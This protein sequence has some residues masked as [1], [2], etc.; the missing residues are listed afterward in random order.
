[1]FEVTYLNLREDPTAQFQ[2]QFGGSSGRVCF[3]NVLVEPVD[4]PAMSTYV[5]P[6][7]TGGPLKNYS[8]HV[9]MGTA[10]D[11]PIFLS[12]PEHNAIVA[13]EFSMITPA[14]AMKMNII[15]PEQV[16][17]DFTEADA[18]LSWAQENDLEFH[19]HPLLW[20]RDP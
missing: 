2:F 19:G 14:N 6:S 20:Q 10:V 7:T 4:P 18:L 5:S 17:F 3:D 12:S 11:T 13:G 16:V 9:K 1:M 15:E 8:L